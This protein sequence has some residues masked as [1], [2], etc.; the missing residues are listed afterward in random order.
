[1]SNLDVYSMSEE[2]FIAE[3]EKRTTPELIFENAPVIYQY[4]SDIF[5]QD[6][7]DSLL[8]EWAFGWWSEKTGKDYNVIYSRWLREDVS[9]VS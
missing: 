8:R 9:D 5:N 6:C 2:Q 3:L 7:N 1:M 4:L